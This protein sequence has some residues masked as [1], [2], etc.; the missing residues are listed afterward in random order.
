[1]PWLPLLIG[2]PAVAV[3]LLWSQLFRSDT[4][5]WLF[6]A[7]IY[8]VLGLSWAMSTAPAIMLRRK[9]RLR[10]P[11]K[12]DSLVIRALFEKWQ[13]A[14]I[15]APQPASIDD[16]RRFEREYGVVLPND[17]RDYFT[18]I[19][20]TK[21]GWNGQDDEHALGF[22]HLHQV[23]TFAEEGISDDP[24]VVSTFVFAEYAFR[25]AVYGVRLSADPAAPTA[26]VAR[27]PYGRFEV[28]ATFSEFLLRY[29]L[30]DLSVLFPEFVVVADDTGIGAEKDGVV[31]YVVTWPD[32]REIGIEIVGAD[33]EPR[34]SIA[35]WVIS[36]HRETMPF[37]APLDT[38]AG[39]NVVRARIRSLKGFD[40]VAF[41]S[42]RSA[43]AR[44]ESG[45][46]VVWRAVNETPP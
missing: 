43:E 22:W 2:V 17:V 3:A 46:F 41:Q 10:L 14:G 5:R 1:M 23:R 20:G 4:A 18:S 39:G 24:D 27:F 44:G 31:S 15:L 28:A 8:G 21:R 32:V 6:L 30:D 37:M 38:V 19:N 9:L 45:R 35:Y 40:D 7:A 36:G 34:E 12:R 26:V 33:E 16:V 13:V 11:W 25:F 42:A 29:L